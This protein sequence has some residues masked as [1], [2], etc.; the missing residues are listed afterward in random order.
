MAKTTNGEPTK[1][2]HRAMRKFIGKIAVAGA[3]YGAEK[4][5]ESYR[6][7]RAQRKK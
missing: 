1:K 3:V 7:K 4:L 6:K 5:I 2:N